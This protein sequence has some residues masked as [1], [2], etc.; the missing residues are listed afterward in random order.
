MSEAAEGLPLLND[1]SILDL[2]NDSLAAI[3][4]I[5]LPPFSETD[6]AFRQLNATTRYARET[7]AARSV[8]IEPAYID[9]DHIEDHSVFYSKSL[10]Q[11]SNRCIRLC[12]FTLGASELRSALSGLIDRVRETPKNY[13]SSCD[14]FS[15]D[16]FVGFM[17]IRPLP[18]SP[19]G[20]SVLKPPPKTDV[21]CLPQTRAHLLGLELTVA[22]VPYQQQDVAVSACATTALWSSLQAAS[23]QEPIRG[24]TPAQI[25][26]LASKYSLPFGRPMPSEGLSTGQMCQAIDALGVAPS[27]L[28]AEDYED[29]RGC[30]HS[31]LKSGIAPVLILKPVDG[32]GPEL[33]AVCATGMLLTP[34]GTAT[35]PLN[36][37]N[38]AT[39]TAA[40]LSHLL[41]HDDRTAPYLTSKLNSA[42]LVPIIELPDG[43]RWRIYQILIPTHPKIRL[44]FLTLRRVAAS[45]IALKAFEA[46]LNADAPIGPVTFDC[47][48]ERGHEYHRKLLLRCGPAHL[49]DVLRLGRE[50]PLPRYVAII[51][52]TG[53]AG[54]VEVLL[55]TT[56]TE[57]NLTAIAVLNGR[58]H[59]PVSVA[60]AKAMIEYL[61][62]SPAR[63]ISTQ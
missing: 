6:T 12:F 46:A 15:I 52:L 48:M 51:T 53:A 30:L 54:H 23:A 50:V 27:L 21:V 38:D 8:L 2:S 61:R 37:L 55:D 14:Q 62:L 44:S 28:K 63:L 25:T 10:V 60:V 47:W 41:I 59:D 42:G 57:K 26:T 18:G 45:K 13:H 58:T 17:V 32:G 22:G 49:S 5:E 31:A 36:A 33:H 39:D 1:T 7:L 35:S 19:V 40:R 29:T 3:L 56:S 16:H 24:A 20:R 34:A 9:R 43:E 4:K 11:Y